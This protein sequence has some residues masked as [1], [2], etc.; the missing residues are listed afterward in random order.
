MRRNA[1]EG[2]PYK[3][4]ASAEQLLDRVAALDDA[5]R[6]AVGDALA[7]RVDLQR[8][9]QRAEQ[10]LHRHRTLLHARPRRVGLADHLPALDAAARQRH[11]KRPRI[12]VAARLA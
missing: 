7:P 8:L 12:V 5:D 2:V 9:A 1:T 3:T 11:A 10:V 6:P 4:P